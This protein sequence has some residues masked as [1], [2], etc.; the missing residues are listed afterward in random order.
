M[1]NRLTNRPQPTPN[2]PRGP[3]DSTD[4]TDPVPFY[5][6]GVRGRLIYDLPY[7][8]RPRPDS[9]ESS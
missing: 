3:I 1:G 2:R 5:R 6:T 9:R 7:G 4:P 8:N